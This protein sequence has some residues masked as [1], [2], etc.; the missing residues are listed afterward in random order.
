MKL[1]DFNTFVRLPSGTVFAPY[2]PC[3]LDGELEIKVDEG[4]PILSPFIPEGHHFNGVLPLS[5]CFGDDST[6]YLYKP[7]DEAPASFEIYDGSN[8]DYRSHDLFLIF[9]ENDI[10]RLIKVLEWAK[11]GCEGPNPGEYRGDE[12]C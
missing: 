11:I 5:P 4:R 7:G 10:D 12:E 1:V 6:I 8:I 2:T 3:C 9:D